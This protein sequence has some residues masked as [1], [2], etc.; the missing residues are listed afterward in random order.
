MANNDDTE[1]SGQEL[2]ILLTVREA[3]EALKVAEVSVRRLL[4][5]GQLAAY[6][7]GRNWRIPRE[8]IMNYLTTNTI[9][10]QAARGE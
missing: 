10:Q 4:S 3:A 6:K 1:R 5:S 8:S 2:P 9:F 7:V